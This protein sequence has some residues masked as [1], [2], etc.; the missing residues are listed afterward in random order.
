MALAPD[1]VVDRWLNDRFAC[2]YCDYVADTPLARMRDL[3]I[4]HFKPDGGNEFGNLRAACRLCNSIKSD[5]TFFETDAD[6]RFY[7]QVYQRECTLPWYDHNVVQ[8]IR[9]Q[10]P[11]RDALRRLYE[12]EKAKLGG[13]A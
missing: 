9:W 4:D 5:L 8:G 6:V 2:Q 11:S 1:Q 13:V 3:T 7:V 12:M 10:G